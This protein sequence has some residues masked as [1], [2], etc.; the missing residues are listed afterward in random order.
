MINGLK[1]S[2]R[3]IMESLENRPLLFIGYVPSI[4]NKGQFIHLHIYQIYIKS[5]METCDKERRAPEYQ[6]LIMT[7]C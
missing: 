3:V 6:F 7:F 4:P 2:C 5:K 1:K